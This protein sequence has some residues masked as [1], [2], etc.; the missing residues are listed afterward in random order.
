MRLNRKEELTEEL[1]DAEQASRDCFAQGL[2]ADAARLN[3]RANEIRHMLQDW[4]MVQQMWAEKMQ[5][6]INE[7]MQR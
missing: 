1:A 5:P 3:A 7:I 4:T 2:Y 6:V